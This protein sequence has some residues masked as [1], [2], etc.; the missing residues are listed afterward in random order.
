MFF[1]YFTQYKATLVS[2][3]NGCKIWDSLYN[4]SKIKY[5]FHKYPACWRTYR[6]GSRQ[7]KFPGSHESLNQ[8]LEGIHYKT[9]MSVPYDH[10]SWCKSWR[11]PSKSICSLIEGFSTVSCPCWTL[12]VLSFLKFLEKVLHGL[13]LWLICKNSWCLDLFCV[14]WDLVYTVFIRK[15]QTPL[16]RKIEISNY[17]KKAQTPRIFI[18]F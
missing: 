13:C 1:L 17:D 15:A 3:P 6:F 2:Y 9:P 14:T 4:A 18:E 8:M 11:R 12:S 5:L 7:T 16:S 10:Q